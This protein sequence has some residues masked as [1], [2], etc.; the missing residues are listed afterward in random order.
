PH[1]RVVHLGPGEAD[2]RLRDSTDGLRATAPE[3]SAATAL[4]RGQRRGLV[5][6]ALLVVLGLVAAPHLTLAVLVGLATVVYL[7]ALGYRV[8]LYREG[9][10]PGAA[11]E[12]GDEE[13]RGLV[14]ADLPLYT[15]LVPAYREPEVIGSLLAS[16]DRLEYPRDRLDVKVLLESDDPETLAAVAAAR[17]GPW[18]ETVIVP[19]AQPRTKPKALNYGLG[20]ARGSLVAIYDAEDRPDPL[21]LRRAVA[22]F[23]SH[24]PPS[25]ACLQ[26]SLSY[27]NAGQNRITRWFTAEYLTWFTRL[28]PGLVRLGAPVPLGGT[29]NHIRR[30]VLLDVGGWDPFNVT[31]DADLGIRLHRA[32]HQ[33]AIL[34]SVT[35]EEANSD[36]VNWVRQRSRWY[37]GYLLTWLVHMRRPRLLW[38]QLG[39]AGFAGYN[40]FVGG[41]PLMALLNPLFWTLTILWFVAQP[42]FVAQLF[43]APVYY[44]AMASWVLGNFTVLYLDLISIRA[45]GRPDLGLTVLTAPAY[46]VMMSMAAVKAAVQ[47]VQSPALWE[48]TFHG[49]SLG[50]PEPVVGPPIEGRGAA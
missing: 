3:L 38:R 34:G 24:V 4:G 9:L 11:I 5:V 21:Q 18:V 50:R 23:R 39:P 14:D 8:L 32:G 49:L 47:V 36:F 17:P 48:K 46:W 30:P 29:S 37:K 25:V 40:L 22:A 15:V 16:L 33:V 10:R 42:A 19:A 2:R 27:Y 31:E 43:P 7:A 6:L 26:A 35:L 41:T 44:P 28:L 20:L 13:A 12:V 45:A 1:L